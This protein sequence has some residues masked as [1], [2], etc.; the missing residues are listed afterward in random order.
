MGKSNRPHRGSLEYWPHRRAKKLMPRVRNWPHVAEPK[1]EGFVGV[2]AGMTHVT[3]IDDSEAP[4]KGS[5][6]ARAVTIIEM[7]KVHIYGIRLYGTKFYKGAMAEVHDKALA[8]K[9]GIKNGK[10]LTVAAVKQD[11]SKYTD[12][13]A[14]AFC[15]ESNLGFGNKRVLRFEMPV[16]GKDVA[17]KV[18][19][20]EQWLGKEIKISNVLNPGEYIDV[21]TI[22]KGKGWAG[23][24]K[25][26]GVARLPRK[27][28][29]KI[30]HLGVLGAWHPAKVLY[31][32][33]H[34][35]HMGYNF[36]TELNKRILKI[37]TPNDAATVNIKGGFLNYG[38]IK[39]D[40]MI[41]DGSIPGPARRLLR[42]RKAMRST[43]AVKVPNV[44]YVSLA[45]KQG[46]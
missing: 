12:A 22:S 39:N 35:G 20:I 32:V 36:R 1:F 26:F 11:L 4:S 45:S 29:G 8:Q 27:A 38:L 2:K 44:T 34:A 46:G 42:I 6:I 5:E 41:L 23:V 18:T 37:G 30:R 28:T 10:D 19:F 15:D 7:P 17:E 40:F 13:T 33:P 21:T 43:S 31:T 9:V 25:R 14:L 16:G 24:I 3:M